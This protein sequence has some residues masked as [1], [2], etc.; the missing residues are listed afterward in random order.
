MT[1]K[2]KSGLLSADGTLIEIFLA[3]DLPREGRRA[4]GHVVRSCSH[5][6]PYV[7]RSVLVVVAH[8]VHHILQCDRF[9]RLHIERHFSFQVLACSI[10]NVFVH[11]IAEAI[12]DTPDTSIAVAHSTEIIGSIG[13]AE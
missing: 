1:Y 5:L 10:V 9:L 12:E 8:A 6:I 11:A 13:I 7:K 4:V 3:V 2:T